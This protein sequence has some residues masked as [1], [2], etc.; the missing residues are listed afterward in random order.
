MDKSNNIVAKIGDSAQSAELP[1]NARK[2][3]HDRWLDEWYLRMRFL[4]I[5]LAVVALGMF[6]IMK[7]MDFR[8]KTVFIK[9][10]CQLC[11]DLNPEVTSCF[12]VHKVSIF[13]DGHGGWRYEN[14]S[15]YTGSQLGNSDDVIDYRT[16][17]ITGLE[18]LNP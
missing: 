3:E 10:P 12:A 9:T 8:Y 15:M 4:L 6:C 11:M 16:I 14:G 18:N 1:S 13:P 7:V 2:F 17:N 5:M